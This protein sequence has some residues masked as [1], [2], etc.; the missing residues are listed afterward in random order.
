M[1]VS[2]AYVKVTCDECS[3]IEEVK[4]TTII[5]GLDAY[6]ESLGWLVFGDQHYCDVCSR[7]NGCQIARVD[8]LLIFNLE[9]TDGS[10]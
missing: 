9:T 1:S 10:R 3:V 2:T 8:D 7:I 6:M 4:L 5:G